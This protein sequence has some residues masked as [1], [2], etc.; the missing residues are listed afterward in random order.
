[1]VKFKAFHRMSVFQVL[2]KA[3]FIIKDFQ[4]S[5]VDSSLCEPWIQE[6]N[7]YQSVTLAFYGNIG[8][9]FILKVFTLT[10]NSAKIK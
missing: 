2:F 7:F 4:D 3:N 6:L 5:N 8:V 10:T 1:M 9:F